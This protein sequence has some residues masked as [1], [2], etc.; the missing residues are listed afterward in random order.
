M[1][2]MLK[3]ELR[4]LLKKPVF[5]IM[6]GLCV[7]VAVFY[8]FSARENMNYMIENM[9]EIV[10]EYDYY[11]YEKSWVKEHF[12]EYLSPQR[13]VLNE[14][15]LILPSVLAIFTA[16]FVCEDRARGT[17]KNIYARGYS[18]TSVFFAKFIVSSAVAAALY[19]L[20][21]GA[22]YL[23]GT[24]VFWTAPFDVSPQTVKGFWLL[25][26]GR[27]ILILA[28]NAGYFM[29][30]EFIGGNTG[31]SIASNMFAP[32]V[33]NGILYLGLSFFFYVILKDLH[34][35][36]KYAIIENIIEYWIY[37]LTISGFNIEMK[38]DAY[39]WHLVA[40]AIYFIVFMG[41][42]WLISVKKEVKN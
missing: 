34:T 21:V 23:S 25:V 12:A 15:W 11:G 1:G 6:L 26:L 10:S 8:V 37:S 20:V 7:G 14:F 24:I 33:M 5:Y 32:S 3:F 4:R 36:N 9:S 40:A 22:L 27:L 13:L 28:A 31:F 35:D 17:I 2:N 30:S 16:I 18:R 39:V 41:L 29:V 42:S 38:P 19:L